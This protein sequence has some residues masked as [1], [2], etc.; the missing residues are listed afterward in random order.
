M[1]AIKQVYES[2][3]GAV[4]QTCEDAIKIDN[5]VRLKM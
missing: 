2:N 3:F 1:E 5:S 4:Y